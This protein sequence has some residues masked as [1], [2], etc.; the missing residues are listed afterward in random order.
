MKVIQLTQGYQTIVDNEDYEWLMQWKWGILR[1]GN[2]EVYGK[3]NVEMPK[4]DGKRKRYVLPIHRAIMGLCKGDK[5]VVDHINHDTLDNRRINL[6]IA[7]LKQ[8]LANRKGRRSEKPGYIGV[9]KEYK[10]W[11]GRFT[12]QGRE[13]ASPRLDTIAEAVM[14]Y[15]EVVVRYYGEFAKTNVISDEDMKEYLDRKTIRETL[16]DVK[17]ICPTCKLEKSIDLF[18]KRGRSKDGLWYQCKTCTSEGQKKSRN[19][20]KTGYI[21]VQR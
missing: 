15:N 21:L 16:S 12:H 13:Y 17:K 7:T 20:K 2:G 8:N 14:W 10:K 6:R 1:Q 11:K 19:I 5:R 4:R 18:Y 3:R 9:R